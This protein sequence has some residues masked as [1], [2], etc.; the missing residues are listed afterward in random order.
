MR[1]FTTRLRKG[2]GYLDRVYFPVQIGSRE[3]ASIIVCLKKG[4]VAVS[5]SKQVE[6]IRSKINIIKLNA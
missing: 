3:T 6:N 5:Y 2:G 1:E 4:T